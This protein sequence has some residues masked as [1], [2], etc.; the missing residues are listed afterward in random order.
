MHGPGKTKAVLR[1]VLTRWTAHYM[2][3]NRL[4]E[5]RPTLLAVIVN[6]NARSDGQRK[7]VIGDRKAKEK[8]TAMIKI[9]E[10]GQFWH[11]ILRYVQFIFACL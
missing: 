7:I 3:F 4:L 9:I 10:N 5:L 2:A 1:A 8:A 11:A 6:D